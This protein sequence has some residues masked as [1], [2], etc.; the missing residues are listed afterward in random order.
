MLL[1][2]ALMLALPVASGPLRP[3]ASGLRG[4]AEGEPT[5][6]PPT[7]PP[8]AAPLK[9]DDNEVVVRPESF[10][11]R[12]ENCTSAMEKAIARC[13]TV[14]AASG[15]C[16]VEL[17]RGTYRSWPLSLA[18]GMT[19]RIQAGAV[20]QAPARS[21]WPEP[22]CGGGDPRFRMRRGCYFLTG[23]GIRGFVLEGGGTVKALG[24][25]WWALRRKQHSVWAPGMLGCAHCSDVTIKDATFLDSPHGNIVFAN[26][27]AILVDSI[28]ITAPQDAPNTDGLNVLE[29]KNFTLRNSFISNGDDGI[30]CDDGDNYF[31]GSDGVLIHDNRFVN[32]H[33]ASIGSVRNGTVKN[34]VVRDCSFENTSNG[35]RIKTWIGGSGEV[36]NITCKH[37]PRISP[38]VLVSFQPV[39]AIFLRTDENLVMTSV[40]DPIFLTQNYN[41][42]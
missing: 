29:C 37:S 5:P 34:V 39:S 19:L 38:S 35:A 41:N 42:L 18:S 11:C 28:N 24:A 40:M 20:L 26:S 10:G 22:D 7:P 21:E 36:F 14:T 12:P 3:D 33:G 8:N 15:R 23:T 4:R 9:A 1:A 32:G 2:A 27:T 31:G 17:S 13:A 6:P 30:A 25:P 16:V